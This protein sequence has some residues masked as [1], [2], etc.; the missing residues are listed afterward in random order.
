M[1]AGLFF[2]SPR[3][4]LRVSPDFDENFFSHFLFIYFLT[5][6]SIDQI[7]SVAEFRRYIEK[8]KE[9]RKGRD[10]FGMKLY[11]VEFEKERTPPLCN[12]RC[13]F[14]PFA[15]P[16]QTKQH[17]LGLIRRKGVFVL[18]AGLQTGRRTVWS[19]NLVTNWQMICTESL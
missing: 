6:F 4:Y 9:G 13:R 16:G 11:L 7:V 12:L 15:G 1:P 3:S 14:E 18:C 19:E 8:K 10:P 5:F 17:S 2:P